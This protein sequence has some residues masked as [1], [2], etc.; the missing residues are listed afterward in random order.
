MS[1]YSLKCTKF[2]F[3][4]GAYSAPSDPL[5]GFQEFTSKEEEEDGNGKEKGDGRGKR[6]EEGKGKDRQKRRGMEWESVGKG[7]KGMRKEGRGTGRRHP[8]VLVLI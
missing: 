8:L 1:D 3:G 7:T 5:A 4:G 2:N 6:E